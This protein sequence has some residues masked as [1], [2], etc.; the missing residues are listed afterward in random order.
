M[1]NTADQ[2]IPNPE[3]QPLYDRLYQEVYK[4][5]FPTLQSLLNRLNELTHHKNS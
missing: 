5:L 2:F 1:T 4:P 3:T